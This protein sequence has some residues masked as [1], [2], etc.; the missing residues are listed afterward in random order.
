MSSDQSECGNGRT[1][2]NLEG[3]WYKLSAQPSSFQDCVSCPEMVVIPAGK[4]VMGSSSD[5]PP[6]TTWEAPQHEATIAKSFAMGKF[7]VTFDEWD[8]CVLAGSCIAP[9]TGDHGWGRG[10]RPAILVT[11]HEARSYANWLTRKTGGRYRLP[12]EAEWEYAARA[13][14]IT[15]FN[16]GNS[17]SPNDANY[18]GTKPYN[19]AAKGEYRQKT[20]PVGSF[21]ANAFGLHDM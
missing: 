21:P 16:T 7:E 14:T 15:A 10:R 11:W 12:S 20:S 13:G 8:A 18:D 4:F 3:R 6:H 2:V 19:G 17:I 9:K 1:K 5:E